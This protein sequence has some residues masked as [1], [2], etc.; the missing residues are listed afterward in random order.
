MQIKLLIITG[1]LFAFGAF[2]IALSHR[3]QQAESLKKNRD[4]TKYGVY[5]C[6]VFSLILSAYCSRL[7]VGLILVAIAVAGSIEL[8]LNLKNRNTISFGLSFVFFLFLIFCLGHLLFQNTTPWFS[9]FVFVFLLVATTDSFSQLWGKLLGN[10]KLCPNLSPGK[11]LEGLMGGILSTIAISL[12]LRF[13]LPDANLSHLITIALIIGISATTGDLL[14]SYIKRRLE[15]KDFSGLLPGHGGILD[16]FDSLIVTAPV[17]YWTRV[18][19]F[20]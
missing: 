8:Y 11:T 14:F 5:L 9:G 3:F 13:L 1:S 17:F 6:F 10:Y 7:L 2:L 19:I 18:L 16:R 4:W 12:F 20:N 15:I